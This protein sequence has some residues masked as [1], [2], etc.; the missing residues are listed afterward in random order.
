MGDRKEFVP[1]FFTFFC[2][3]PRR[4]CGPGRA[5]K[6]FASVSLPRDQDGRG[7]EGGGRLNTFKALK[8]LEKKIA[9]AMGMHKFSRRFPA[10]RAAGEDDCRTGNGVRTSVELNRRIR[11]VSRI[12]VLNGVGS[13]GSRGGGSGQCRISREGRERAHWPRAI[14]V[15]EGGH[16]GWA[17]AESVPA[18]RTSARLGTRRPSRSKHG[19]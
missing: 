19:K 8:M 18:G 12:W 16:A 7:A 10:R 1:S 5:N 9:N 13:L 3:S 6:R 2:F 15:A 4:K 17:V 14:P 11:G